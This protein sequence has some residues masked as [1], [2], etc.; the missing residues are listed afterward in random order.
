MN[1]LIEQEEHTEKCREHGINL[2]YFCEDC[3]KSACCEC[4]MFG[5]H[6]NHSFKPINQIYQ[7][8][9]NRI[10]DLLST[11]KSK[12]MEKEELLTEI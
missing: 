6:Q 3:S 1:S 9:Y 4:K 10:R 5:E 12:I 11:L 2:N 7:D 8:K